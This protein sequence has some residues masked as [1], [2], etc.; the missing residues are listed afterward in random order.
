MKTTVVILH[1]PGC[2]MSG[3]F[4]MRA[5]GRQYHTAEARESCE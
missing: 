1:G 2:I 5:Q 3:D 4:A